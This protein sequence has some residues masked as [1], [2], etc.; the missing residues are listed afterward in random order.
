MPGTDGPGQFPAH[1][2][3]ASSLVWTGHSVFTRGPEPECEIIGV[4]LIRGTFLS[5]PPSHTHPQFP[6]T[7]MFP[8]STHFL[9]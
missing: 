1:N 9:C 5:P 8:K 6:K 4:Q 2:H 3:I 7:Q